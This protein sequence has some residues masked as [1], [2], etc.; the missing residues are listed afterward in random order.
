MSPSF[1]CVEQNS[2]KQVRHADHDFVH[3]EEM[4]N[5]QKQN[6]GKSGLHRHYY[7][8]PATFSSAKTTLFSSK[9][10]REKKCPAPLESGLAVVGVLP[11][12]GVFPP[13]RKKELDGGGRWRL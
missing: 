7:Q 2:F 9:R 1:N 10:K 5:T 11:S 8:R 12:D 6:G 4:E 3:A 13:P